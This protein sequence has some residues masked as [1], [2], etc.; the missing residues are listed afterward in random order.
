VYTKKLTAVHV[1]Y[2]TKHRIRIRRI[3]KKATHHVDSYKSK[4]HI[5]IG[6]TFVLFN[7]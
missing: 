5:D 4:H 3:K 7:T 1:K 6:T 2:F